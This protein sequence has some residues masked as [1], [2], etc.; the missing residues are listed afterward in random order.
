MT[1]LLYSIIIFIAC[2]VGATV[3]IGGGIIIKPALDLIGVHGVEAVG[4]ISSCAVLAMSISSSAKHIA[5]KTE[6][7]KKIALLVSAGSILGGISGN[8]VFDLAFN[9]LNPGTVKGI[10]AVIIILF[11]IFVLIYVNSKHKKSFRL[12]NPALILLTGIMLGMFSA[13]LGIGGGPVNT[14]FLAIL[15][16]FTVKESSVY[17]IAI[18][19]FSQLSQLVTMFISNRFEPFRSCF[20]VAAA[21]MAVAVAGGLIGSKLN[22]KL[23]DKEITKIFSVVLIF[24]SFI[25]VYNAAAGFGAI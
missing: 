19:F 17:S 14:A 8:A 4:F 18:I 2:T 15:F 11:I 7:D 21:A 5:S 24:V 1:V 20:G 6:F 9:R 25:N 12:K 10:Q 3:G 13:F 23:S 22:K 16:S